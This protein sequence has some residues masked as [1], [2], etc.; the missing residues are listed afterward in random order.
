VRERRAGKVD[1]APLAQILGR[2]VREV[3]ADEPLDVVSLVS[4]DGVATARDDRL[5]KSNLRLVRARRHSRISASG[6]KYEPGWL[7]AV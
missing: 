5:E 1:L 3:G 6:S 7:R 2:D 4:A